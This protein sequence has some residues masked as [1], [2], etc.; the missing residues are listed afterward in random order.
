MRVTFDPTIKLS[1]ILTSLSFIL[2]V[3]ALLYSQQK[4]RDSV[5]HERAAEARTILSNGAVKLNRWVQLSDAIFDDAQIELV[6]ASEIW[7]KDG[8]VIGARD[9]LWRQWGRLFSE[10]HKKVV[11][12]KIPGAYI[13]LF[14]I[15]ETLAKAYQDSLD[16]LTAIEKANEE[17]ML[18]HTQQVVLSFGK[19]SAD[20]VTAQMGNKLREV[21]A[22]DREKFT[23]Q[24][25]VIAVPLQRRIMDDIKQPDAQLLT[26]GP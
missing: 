19:G 23:A 7:G 2:A 10:F 14:R 9:Y 1:D 20:R 4:D 15:N 25:A 12:E 13:D 3:F 6:Q 17:S 21:V 11:D 22:G 5:W 24:V 18:L 26:K 8:N 16:K